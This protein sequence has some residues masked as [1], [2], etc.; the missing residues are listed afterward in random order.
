MKNN[1]FTLIEI[2]I[3]SSIFAVIV[4]FAISTF[5]L[6]IKG[7]KQEKLSGNIIQSG[8][9]ILENITRE[10]RLAKEIKVINPESFIILSSNGETKEYKKNGSNFALKIN[11]GSEQNLLPP[12]MEI[13]SVKFEGVTT[14][15]IGSPQLK[16]PYLEMEIIIQDKDYASKPAT[17][18][19]R[20][21]FRTSVVLRN[22][23]TK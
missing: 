7:Q 4:I 21:V 2:L 5:S 19:N 9:F 3:A 1:G 16:Q 22:F 14:V 15:A 13:G 8:Q 6:N 23:N 11:N 17:E 20:Q 18:R 10:V 12:L